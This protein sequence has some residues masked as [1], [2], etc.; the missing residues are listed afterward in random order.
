[1]DA[2]PVLLWLKSA[3]RWVPALAD[4]SGHL[5]VGIQP[6]TVKARVWNTAIVSNTNILGTDIGCDQSPSFLLVYVSFSKDGNFSVY[7][8]VSG[9]SLSEY[10][11]AYRPLS[12]YAGY[13]FSVPW[14][15]G[16]SVNFRYSVGG[17]CRILDVVEVTR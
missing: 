5:Q 6:Q 4:S 1:M 2:Q 13:L 8:T 3:L 14:R 16:D 17:T 7:R 15:A 12:A 10:M 9:T 11:N